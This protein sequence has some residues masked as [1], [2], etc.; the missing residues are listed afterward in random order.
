MLSPLETSFMMFY[1]HFSGLVY[2]ENL[3]YVGV[4]M[5]AIQMS[6][7]QGHLGFCFD[8]LRGK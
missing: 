8:E 1:D 5:H 3:V 4:L 2:A 6:G 7:H